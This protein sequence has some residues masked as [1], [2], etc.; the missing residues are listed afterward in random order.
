MSA[1][2]LPR[3]VSEAAADLWNPL[4][5]EAISSGAKAIGTH[6]A[7]VPDP[8][9]SVEGLFPLRLRASG[10]G[11]TALADT[12]L[13]SVLCSYSRTLLEAALDGRFDFLGG[14]VFASSCDH[15]RRL[16]DNLLYLRPP[17]FSHLLDLPHRADEAAVRW[18][19]GELG[20]LARALSEGFG[21]DTGPRA[22][23]AAIARENRHRALLGAIGALRALESPP[24]TGAFFHSLVVASRSAPRASLTKALEGIRDA[25][26]GSEPVRGVRARILLVGSELCDPAWIRVLESQGALVVGD[27]FCSGS[28]YGVEPIPETSDPLR[29]LAEHQLRRTRCPRMMEDFGARLGDLL[30]LAKSLRADGVVIQTLKFCDLWG[31]ESGLLARTLREAGVPVLRLERE[32]DLTG[33]GQLRTRIQAFLES[34]GR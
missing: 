11:G 13:G 5:S 19:E 10:A 33:E 24:L 6:C 29:A 3:E 14:W 18:F 9:L 25:L 12:Y 32:H 2:A 15:S 31:V 21:V 16:G 34:M 17:T 28:M 7:Y 30:G 27:R 4:V 22:I 26:L 8:L 20:R 23:G 1:L